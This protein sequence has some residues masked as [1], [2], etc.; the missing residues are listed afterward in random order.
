[1]YISKIRPSGSRAICTW[2]PG[3]EPTLLLPL[4]SALLW[5][6]KVFRGWMV[7]AWALPSHIAR[8]QVLGAGLRLSL[9][10]KGFIGGNVQGPFQT[11]TNSNLL[12]IKTVQRVF[13]ITLWDPVLLMKRI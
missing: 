13:G 8:G 11:A 6:Q 2:L 3:V 4:G 10:P 12:L 5:S 7:W 9:L 1:M